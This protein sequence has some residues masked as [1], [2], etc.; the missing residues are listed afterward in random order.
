MRVKSFDGIL[1]NNCELRLLHFL[2]PLDDVKFN[3]T[4]LAEESGVSRATTGKVVKK[5]ADRNILNVHEGGINEYSI[6]L[7]SPL[8]QSIVDFNNVIIENILGE[9]ELF[10]INAYIVGKNY[11]IY[12]D[13]ISNNIIPMENI[14]QRE[15]REFVESPYIYDPMGGEKSSFKSG[16]MCS[17]DV[18][19][20]G[21]S[22]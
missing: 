5:F 22:V 9:Q 11:E 7:K 2:L 20:E 17:Y 3:I 10:E 18:T 15:E 19:A 14:G 1:G 8:V 16:E 21:S 13:Q 4:E 6:N 12:K